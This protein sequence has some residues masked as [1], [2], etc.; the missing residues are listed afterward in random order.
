MKSNQ[1]KR[2]SPE[3]RFEKELK[4]KKN[5]WNWDK[6]IYLSIL[7]LSVLGISY[8]AF[9]KIY[10]V[11]ADGRVLFQTLDI[12]LVND[13]QIHTLSCSEGDSVKSGDLLFTYINEKGI[14]ENGSDAYIRSTTDHNDWK[15][16][17]AFKIEEE[18]SL[19]EIERN[20]CKLLLADLEKD[21]QR[22]KKEVYLDVYTVDKL[23]PYLKQIADLKLRI[24]MLEKEQKLL[25]EMK[26]KL[27]EIFDTAD[28]TLIVSTSNDGDHQELNNPLIQGFYS[29]VAGF[30][31]HIFKKDY[32][33]VLESEH[34]LSL[35]MPKAKVYVKVFFE[36]SDM[37][38]LHIGDIVNVDF[39]NGYHSKG[40]VER[41]YFD[42]YDLPVHLKNEM[43]DYN[44]NIEADIVPLEPSE[45]VLWRKSQKLDV[46]ITKRRYF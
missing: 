34:I 13:I 17:E 43:V 7:M 45:E 35:H 18:I 46:Q 38:H 8:Y 16:K 12:Q 23:N 40:K 42:T 32:E 26:V 2:N 14:Q 15:S 37:R 33:T 44:N 27:G 25:L 3:L 22:I 9:N 6:V 20:N 28:S 31:S 39:A 10:Y 11:T 4:P 41:F 36:Q 5:K 1:F 29:P 30:I 24:S 21:K 19:K